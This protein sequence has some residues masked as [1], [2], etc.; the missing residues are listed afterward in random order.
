M[1]DTIADRDLFTLTDA[2]DRLRRLRNAAVQAVRWNAA[3]PLPDHEEYL[4]WGPWGEESLITAQQAWGRRR[5][6]RTRVVT[7]AADLLRFLLDTDITD[8]GPGL[9]PGLQ[10]RLRDLSAEL[11]WQEWYTSENL[12]RLMPFCDENIKA[13][14]QALAATPVDDTLAPEDTSPPI[15]LESR[16]LALLFKYPDWTIPQITDHLGVHR[17]MAYRWPKFRAAA[18][19]A[20]RMKPRGAK[21]RAARPRRGHKTPDGTVE[22]Y[23]GRDDGE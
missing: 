18:E 23:S 17:S 10:V 4:R 2:L 14:S 13:L 20:G 16:A 5:E 9:P 3:D 15:D 22:A 12:P 7:H 19:K 6:D 1:S 8:I 21:V 11:A